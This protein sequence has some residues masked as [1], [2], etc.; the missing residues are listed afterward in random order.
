MNLRDGIIW[1]EGFYDQPRIDR[2]WN[3]DTTDFHVIDM[4][5]VNKTPKPIGEPLNIKS[6]SLLFDEKAVRGYRFTLPAHATLQLPQGKAPIVVI[7]LTDT[8]GN[9]VGNKK[10]F[11][12]KGDFIFLEPGTSGTLHQFGEGQAQFCRF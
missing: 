5:L 2:V 9:V 3:S 10:K 4:E 7:G 1:F 6:F 8:K 11:S 12:K